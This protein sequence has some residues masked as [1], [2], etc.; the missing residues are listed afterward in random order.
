MAN[1][2]M[3]IMTITL[4]DA[5]GRIDYVTDVDGAHLYC[6]AQ[7]SAETRHHHHVEDQENLGSTKTVNHDGEPRPSRVKVYVSYGWDENHYSKIA[8]EENFDSVNMEIRKINDMMDLALAE[9][10]YQ[11]YVDPIL[12]CPAALS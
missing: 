10:D 2:D 5:S 3:N 4:E 11:K 1:K 8:K 6:I 12:F 9:A 7:I